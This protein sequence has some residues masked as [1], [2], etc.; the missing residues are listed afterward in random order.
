M[1]GGKRTLCGGAAKADCIQAASD[2]AANRWA[3]FSARMMVLA[4]SERSGKST[5]MAAPENGLVL[6][7]RWPSWRPVNETRTAALWSTSWGKALR[8]LSRV[9][10][11]E[12]GSAALEIGR[13]HV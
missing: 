5:T 12:V 10:M 1:G 3:R 9:A 13:A 7:M 11:S 2:E 6:P 4:D 8:R